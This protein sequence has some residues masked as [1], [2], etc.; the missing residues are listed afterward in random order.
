MTYRLTGLHPRQP[1]Y[2]RML[3]LRENLGAI[4]SGGYCITGSWQRGGAQGISM[5]RFAR[6]L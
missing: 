6:Q 2:K 1:V 5:N 3:E 4:V